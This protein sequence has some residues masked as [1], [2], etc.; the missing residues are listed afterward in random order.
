M[1]RFQQD[2]T[3]QPREVN[4]LVDTLN[5]FEE[6]MRMA[7]NTPSENSS[8]YEMFGRILEIS[9]RRTEYVYNL[10]RSHEISD[11]TLEYLTHRGIVDEGLIELWQRDGYEKLCCVLCVDKSMHAGGVCVCRVP[12]KDRR[13]EGACRVCHCSGCG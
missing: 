9:R 2:T 4:L 5:E 11:I 3:G 7:E 8:H 13:H 6:E 12:Q 10:W 1:P